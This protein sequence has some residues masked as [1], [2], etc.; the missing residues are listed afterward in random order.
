M[1]VLK[2]LPCRYL[3]GE[4]DDECSVLNCIC[5]NPV[6]CK[7]QP[8]LRSYIVTVDDLSKYMLNTNY[9]HIITGTEIDMMIISRT[10]MLRGEY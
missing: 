5:P 7:F 9:N 3:C 1:L 10:M 2:P 6:R 8:N 4:Y